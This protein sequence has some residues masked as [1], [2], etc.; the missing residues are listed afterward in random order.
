[1]IKTS[2]PT[3]SGEVSIRVRL[4]GFDGV[5]VANRVAPVLRVHRPDGTTDIALE[6][7]DANEFIEQISLAAESDNIRV[8]VVDGRGVVL[9]SQVISAT[10]SAVPLALDR[11]FSPPGIAAAPFALSE[12]LSTAWWGPGARSSGHLGAALALRD[13][14]PVG[15]LYASAVGRL[16]HFAFDSRVASNPLG[17]D[18][19]ADGSAW[20]GSRWTLISPESTGNLGIEPA[21]RI[22]IPMSAAG[23]QTRIEPSISIGSLHNQWTWAFNFGVRQALENNK[24]R[25]TTP[26]SHLFLVTGATY[27][28]TTWLRL[29]GV[30]DGHAFD[31]DGWLGRVG[32][33]AGAE[34]RGSIFGGL[35][36]H[37]SPWQDA[38]GF[39]SGHITIGIRDGK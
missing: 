1:E 10:S 37:A 33:S 26:T 14:G 13:D 35:S 24:E 17:E 12:G 28:A 2:R 25:T 3:Q 15:Q 38:G 8:D 20:L 21:I 4:V 29:Y 5:D 32:I 23:P 19:G 6:A 22:G 31:S 34:T 27:D 36:L 30:L 16:G 7:S 9:G 18:G 39:T 11:P